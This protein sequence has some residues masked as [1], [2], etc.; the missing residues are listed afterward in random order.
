[1]N[2]GVLVPVTFLLFVFNFLLQL[3]NYIAIMQQDAE[4]KVVP[5]EGP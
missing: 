4:R 1:M 5:E 2:E 3:C